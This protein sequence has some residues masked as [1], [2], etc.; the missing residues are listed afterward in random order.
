MKTNTKSFKHAFTERGSLAMSKAFVIAALGFAALGSACSAAP[1]ETAGTSAQGTP[2]AACLP[3]CSTA[4]RQLPPNPIWSVAVKTA[5]SQW[6]SAWWLRP[7][8]YTFGGLTTPGAASS[9]WSVTQ[10]ADAPIQSLVFIQDPDAFTS[11]LAA[12]ATA[13]MSIW[14]NTSMWAANSGVELPYPSDWSWPLYASNPI[15]TPVSS[16]DFG[17][18]GTL[19]SVRVYDPGVCANK[20]DLQSIHNQLAQ[21]AADQ[22]AAQVSGRLWALTSSYLRDNSP[23]YGGDMA[24]TGGGLEVSIPWGYRPGRYES[25]WWTK[26]VSFTVY[27]LFDWSLQN[28]APAVTPL[29]VGKPTAQCVDGSVLDYCPADRVSDGLAGFS[30]SVAQGL[31]ASIMSQFAQVIPVPNQGPTSCMAV[32]DCASGL[33]YQFFL[34]AAIALGTPIAQYR[35]ALSSTQASVLKNA[36]TVAALD[37]SNWTCDG[38]NAQQNRAGVCKFI[39]KA[40]ALEVLPN[41]LEAVFVPRN[42]Q[43]PTTATSTWT[44]T[45]G[46][47]MYLA[48]LGA[49]S[50]AFKNKQPA[51]SEDA[52]CSLQ[53]A[54]YASPVKVNDPVAR[55]AVYSNKG[56]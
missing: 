52:L 55:A 36:A 33:D 13:I 21:S 43:P 24:S 4:P 22:I 12:N 38:A 16:A 8:G 27:D 53:T 20:I 45:A 25:G 44:T 5:S 9:G 47:A 18:D 14:T 26:G 11:T 28:G 42:F 56:P 40:S 1:G 50:Q 7:N 3:P 35:F 41:Y 6:N 17:A 46:V 30:A 39:P 2:L 29:N 37:L 48:A 10:S 23:S 19:K 32:A 15:T 51:H 34:P 31:N 54:L 49:D